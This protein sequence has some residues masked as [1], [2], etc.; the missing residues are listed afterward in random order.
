MTSN[1]DSDSRPVHKMTSSYSVPIPQI[2]DI[3]IHIMSEAVAVSAS[4]P[5]KW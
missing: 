3:H 1:S 5:A 2:Q 4:R